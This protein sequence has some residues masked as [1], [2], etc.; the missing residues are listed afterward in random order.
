MIV[1]NGGPAQ[2]IDE[3]VLFS[4]DTYSLPFNKGLLLELAPGHK[5][6][7]NSGHG[8]DPEHPGKVVVPEGG[9]GDPDCREVCYYGSVLRVDGEFRMW[10]L[11]RG[12]DEIRRV[13][14]A[15]SS[16][17]ME[18]EKPE[19]G[20]VEHNGH[21][22]NNLVE[23]AEA[24]KPQDQMANFVLV[25]HEPEDP[26]PGRRFKMVYEVDP[27]DIRAA[28]S[29]DGLRWEQS[30]HNPILRG[31]SL[32]PGGLVSF[33]GCYYLNGQG[34]SVAHPIK[35]ARKRTLATYASYDFD[36]WTQ[37]VVPGFRRDPVPPNPPMDFELHRGEQVHMGAS[38]WNRGNVLVGIYG[39]Y[40][41]ETNDRRY[42]T[43][44]LG[45]VTSNDA[46]HFR[47]P[48]PDFKFVPYYEE[49]DDG[50]PRLLQGQGF[51]NEGERSLFWY[52][53]W[54]YDPPRH[55]G[56]RLAT[57]PRDRM[58]FLAPSPESVLRE[59]AEGIEPPHC[60]SCPIEL[61]RAGARVYLNAA[62]SRYSGLRVEVLNRELE[63]LPGYSGEDCVPIG[64]GGM[65]HPVAW[66]GREAL[67]GF[68]H[69]VRIR[70]KWEGIRAED[71]RVFAVYVD[72]GPEP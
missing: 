4:F 46:M 24:G 66:R 53:V 36:H 43:C 2:S 29:A 26:D 5:S 39:Q 49:L 37:A 32:E 35:G 51:A 15:R 8:F 41:N 42:G 65:R 56:V 6:N 44:D 69:P 18:W 28:F 10:Y 52:G 58:G 55:T 48:V 63:P 23:F 33:G 67:E 62:C 19:L 64:E 12:E 54:R 27:S 70:V 9:P 72:E 47:E 14:H 16:D 45:M 38:L 68:G 50:P 13:C 61:E 7:F 59:E 11:G 71:A 31:N 21:K 22:A 1:H 60:I 25:I 57:W 3:A 34:G 30:P 17:G 40:H 20:L